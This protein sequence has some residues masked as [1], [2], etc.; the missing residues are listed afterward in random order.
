MGP[1]EPTAEIATSMTTE[2]TWQIWWRGCFGRR[3]AF[4]ILLVV[5]VYE[6]YKW[7]RLLTRSQY[8]AG[9]RNAH[10][11]AGWER[12]VGLLIED[13]LQRFALGSP[14]LIWFLNRYYAYVHFSAT[15]AFLIWLYARHGDVYGRV[16][17]VLVGTTVVSLA[18]LLYTSPSPRD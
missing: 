15:V 6:G 2:P 9:L 16:R 13:N 10:R 7:A 12:S 11:V 18:C 14:E 1:V 8:A 5:T 3:L 17:R 4:E